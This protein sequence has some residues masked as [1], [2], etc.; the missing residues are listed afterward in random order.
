[1]IVALPVWPLPAAGPHG[2][3]AAL[4]GEIADL[5]AWL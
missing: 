2:V 1:M 5:K 3:K 4:D